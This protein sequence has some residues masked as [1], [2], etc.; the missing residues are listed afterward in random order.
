VCFT[1]LK[2]RSDARP[3]CWR[4]SDPAEEQGGLIRHGA[5]LLFARAET[6]APKLTA[7]S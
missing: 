7:I 2:V 3:K 1:D 6:T 4:T 5:K